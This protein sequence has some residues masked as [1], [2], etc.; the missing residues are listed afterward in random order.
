MDTMSTNSIRELDPGC[1]EQGFN[2]NRYL[3]LFFFFFD[4]DGDMCKELRTTRDHN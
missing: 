1:L 3:H 2:H 4:L